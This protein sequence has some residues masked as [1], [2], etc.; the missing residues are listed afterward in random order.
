M[1]R[2]Y[3]NWGV[4]ALAVGLIA[5]GTILVFLPLAPTPVF[6]GDLRATQGATFAANASSPLERSPVSIDV[7]WGTL[8]QCPSPGYG[9]MCVGP[10]WASVAVFSCGSAPC[11]STTGHPAI[12]SGYGR[13]GSLS[14]QASLGRYYMVVVQALTQ[15]SGTNESVPVSVGAWLPLAAGWLGVTVALA[16]G[17]VAMDQARLST[18]ARPPRHGF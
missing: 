5:L 10:P 2:R 6:S 16:G 14:I 15:P 9:P 4:V 8:G 3:R 18:P 12:A 13:S 1:A 11:Q 7:A 17:L